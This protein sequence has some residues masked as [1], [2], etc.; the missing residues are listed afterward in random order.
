MFFFISCYK[1]PSAS[2]W[3]EAYRDTINGTNYAESRKTLT[4]YTQ[5]LYWRRYS[6]PRHDHALHITG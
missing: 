2:P 3:I 4:A 5:W 1:T 6:L